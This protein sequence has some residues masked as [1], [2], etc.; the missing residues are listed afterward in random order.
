MELGP[1]AI[2]GQEPESLPLRARKRGHSP[3][4]SC[5][6]GLWALGAALCMEPEGGWEEAHGW[7]MGEWVLRDVGWAPR[8]SAVCGLVGRDGM[9]GHCG[10]KA[11]FCVCGDFTLCADDPRDWLTGA[12]LR[13]PVRAGPSGP[14]PDSREHRAAL[15]NRQ[16]C[17]PFSHASA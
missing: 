9:S 8:V 3:S 15:S 6:R 17:H 2:S 10:Q 11:P 12:L 13:P 7:R 14:P 5:H 1:V 16:H 4:A